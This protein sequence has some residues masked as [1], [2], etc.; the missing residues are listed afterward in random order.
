MGRQLDEQA[1]GTLGREVSVKVRAFPRTAI[2]PKGNCRAQYRTWEIPTRGI[3]ALVRD[4]H[5]S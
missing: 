3:A 4:Q 5:L 1:Q 2:V